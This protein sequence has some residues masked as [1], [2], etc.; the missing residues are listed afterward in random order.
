MAN[1]PLVSIL[2]PAYNAEK[3][4]AKAIESALNQTWPSK[5]IIVV[6]DGSSDNTFD[7]A[8]S[9]E[10]AAVRVIHQEKKGASVA[11][12][13]GLQE[14]KGDFIQFLDA[15]DLL[16]PDKIE[17]QMDFFSKE[18]NSGR[19]ASGAWKRF[20]KSAEQSKF[21]PEPLWKDMLPVD[22]LVCS[23]EGHWMMHPAAWLVPRSVA[24]KAGPWDETIT[25]NDDGEYFCRVILASKGIKFCGEAK[26]YYRSGMPSSLSGLKTN[27]A[28][29]S[30]F[31]SYELNATHLLRLEDSLRTRHACA[32]MFQRF[33]YEVYPAV[34]DLCKNAETKVKEWGGTDLK[35]FGGRALQLLSRL[36]GWKLAKRLRDAVYQ[37]GY[38]KAMS[39]WKNRRN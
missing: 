11:R 28:W 35:S 23:W 27:A 8:K 39:A 21:E 7:I 30:L 15:D 13:R 17:L 16:A 36:V 4:I 34:P 26:S 38:K 10:S 9:F 37:C 1:S 5:E 29:A 18:E 6:D 25:L 31:R 20:Y 19:I 2:I 33:I 14:A 32:T 22:W 12:N 3:Y 24:E